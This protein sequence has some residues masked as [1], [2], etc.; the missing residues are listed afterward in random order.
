MMFLPLL[1]LALGA[2]QTPTFTKDIAPILFKNCAECHR[3]GEVAPFPLLSYQDAKQHAEQMVAVTGRRLM[4]PWGAES[5]GEFVGERRLPEKDIAMLKAWVAG[6]APEGNAKAMP[7][8]PAFTEGWQ[9]GKP[10]LIVKMPEAYTKSAEGP[11][12]Y[13]CFVLPVNIPEDKWVKAVE[14]RPG[15]RRCVHHA[16]IYMDTKG[17]ARKMDAGDDGPGY[18]SFA[19]PGFFPSGG[20]GGWAPGTFFRP[21][22]EG[23][24]KLL[25]RGSDIVVQIHY[26]PTG[27][28]ETDQSSIGFYFTDKKPRNVPVLVPLASANILIAPG[29]KD[30]KVAA[31]YTLPVDTEATGVFPHAHLLCR[32]MKGT[33]ILPD[34]TKKPLIWISNWNF[35]WQDQYIYKNHIP[36]PKGTKLKMEFTYDNSADNPRNPNSPPKLVHFGNKTTDEMAILWVQVLCKNPSDL[37]VLAHEL[38][39]ILPGPGAGGVLLDGDMS[40]EIAALGLE[41][42]K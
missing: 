12:I 15:N 4:P 31:E 1:L 39:K 13:R 6:G 20:F 33:A 30:Y 16:L 24:A 36:L 23:V 26:Y 37:P 34:G 25:K 41:A 38:R 11:D 22:P 5:H 21:Y 18:T 40:Q 29:K 7:K 35:N 14:F 3:P 32:D 27:K 10:D 19:G 2:D 28:K 42:S 17:Q 8:A 9:G